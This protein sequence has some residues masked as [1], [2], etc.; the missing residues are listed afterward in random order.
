MSGGT[1]YALALLSTGHVFGWGG[2]DDHQLGVQPNES[3][4]TEPCVTTPRPLAGLENVSSVSAGRAFT[5]ALVHGTVWALGDNEPW[6]Q[7]GVGGGMLS[8]SAPRPIE[9]LPPVALASA[10]EQHAAAVL[11]SSSGP[12]PRFSLT[13]GGSSLGAVWTVNAPVQAL[14]WRTIDTSTDTFGPWSPTVSFSKACSESAPCKYTISGLPA[15]PIEV[16]L[17]SYFIGTTVAIRQAIAT[18]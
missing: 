1:P 15:V 10:G 18:P 6:G 5:L 2:N 4:Q 13:P 11:Q 3:C 14:R 7:L 16:D 9:G 12:M 17:Q 8:T